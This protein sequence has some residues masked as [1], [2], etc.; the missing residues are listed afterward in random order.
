VREFLAAINRDRGVTVLLTTHDLADVERL[1]R[2]LAVID[3]GSCV[4]DGSVDQLKSRFGTHRT[5]IVDLED[6]GPPLRVAGADVVKVDGPR[7]WFRFSRDDVNATDLVA[8][9]A[10][11]AGL[12]DLT[13]EEPDIKD[14]VSQIYSAGRA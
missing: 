12:R 8:R 9:V 14:V 13:L 2:R 3:H 4:F 11:E 7:Q 10:K 5:L 6:A 1:C